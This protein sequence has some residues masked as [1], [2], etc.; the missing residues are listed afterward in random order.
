MTATELRDALQEGRLGDAAK[1]KLASDINVA[2]MNVGDAQGTLVRTS[3][4]RRLPGF[5]DVAPCEAAS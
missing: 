5:D 3:A 4:R 2:V 1:Q